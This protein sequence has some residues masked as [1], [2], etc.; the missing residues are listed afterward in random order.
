[1]L[2]RYYYYDVVVVAILSSTT[3]SMVLIREADTCSVNMKFT[4]FYATKIY[5]CAHKSLPL[6]PF[7]IHVNSV[8]ALS[9]YFHKIHFNI[10]IHL[11]LG[12]LSGLLPWGFLKEYVHVLNLTL[13]AT[14]STHLILFYV[15]ILILIWYK[16]IRR[17]D[18]L[19]KIMFGWGSQGAQ[20]LRI[21][22]LVTIFQYVN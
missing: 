15:I 12:F 1:M 10:I 7:L 2:H 21:S 20:E 3:R 17:D 13:H 22:L 5:Y 19:W 14:I 11:Y 4:E 18:C 6:V 16:W 9:S 8:N